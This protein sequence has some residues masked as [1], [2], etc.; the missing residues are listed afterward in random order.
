MTTETKPDT[1]S[2][3]KQTHS[4]QAETQQILQLMIHSLYSNKEIFI[5]ELVS[6]ASDACDKLRYEGLSNEALYEDDHELR[7]EVEFDAEAKTLTLRDNGIGMT[8][9]EVIDN[10][11]TI[12]RS[13][14]KKFLE[15]LSGDQAKDRQLI[16]Q[17]GVGFYSAFIV[18]DKVALTT[19]RAGQPADTGVRWESEGKGDYTLE[20]VG[21]T[22]RGTEIVL[23]LRDD[24]TEF[25]NSWRLKSIIN[26]YSDHIDLPIRMLTEPEPKG[27]DDSE[28][29]NSADDSDVTDVPEWETVNKA[30]A[31]WTRPKSELKDEDYNEFYKSVAHDFTDPLLWSHNRVEGKLEYT[32]LLYVPSKAPFDMFEPDAKHGVKLYVQR[33]FIMDDAEKMMPRYL[34]FVRGLIDSNDL[35]LNVS[36][37]LLQSNR[38]IDQIRSGSVKKVLG[39]LE[40]LAKNDAE[41]YQEF[42]GQFGEVLKEGPV[43]DQANKDQIAKL[44][45]F[46][47]THAEGDAQTVSLADYIERMQ[48][49]QD[50]IYYLVADSYTAANASP[51]MEIFR[52]KGIEVLLL[53]DRVDEWLVSHL[54]E[55]DGKSLQS[56][57]KGGLEL[58]GEDK[59]DD[60]EEETKDEL[61]KA[62][63]EALKNE[64]AAVKTSKRLVESPACLVV[65]DHEMS[66]H[67]QQLMKQMGQDMPPSKPTLEINADHEMIARLKAKQGDEEFG[68]WCKLVFDQAVLAEGGTLSDPTGFVKRMNS[69]LL[70]AA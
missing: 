68:D 5:R 3:A 16:G 52:K 19:R 12:A 7:V 42:W 55:F 43:E 57:A 56:V 39:A 30:A 54:T 63:E 9:Q 64:V 66:R 40:K 15:A 48:P 50:K 13:G 69:L 26:R 25:L 41:K 6:N 65:A 33:V 61:L 21:E 34:R 23:Y 59:A 18:A 32:S 10:V 29:A 20:E 58:T 17:F 24:E 2:D 38:V 46:A 70:K 51:H 14:T 36:R 4:F 47:S 1:N 67:M 27:E 60:A 37:E 45:R 35:P 28:V 49:E 22:P 44:L 11:G 8:Q 53:S 31:M 62:I